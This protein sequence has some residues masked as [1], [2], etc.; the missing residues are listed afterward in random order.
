MQDIFISLTGADESADNAS[1]V[2]ASDATGS[3]DA[4]ASDASA[5]KT[6]ERTDK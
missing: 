6:A 4:N 2:G 3:P 5:D 1:D